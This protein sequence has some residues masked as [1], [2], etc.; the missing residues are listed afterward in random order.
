MPAEQLL[1]PAGSTAETSA[2]QGD[3][4]GLKAP[5]KRK[6]THGRNDAFCGPLAME[7]GTARSSSPR[8]RYVVDSPPFNRVTCNIR[9]L[10]ST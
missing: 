3:R 9:L 7:S 4:S 8:S 1:F 5:E 10:M 2:A 6:A